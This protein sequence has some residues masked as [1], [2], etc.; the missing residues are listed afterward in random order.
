[1]QGSCDVEVTTGTGLDYPVLLDCLCGQLSLLVLAIWTGSQGWWHLH[2]E[3]RLP[4]SYHSLHALG[5]VIG[6]H[7]SATHCSD[8]Q[9]CATGYM[10]PELLEHAENGTFPMHNCEYCS[11]C[12]E[13][14]GYCCVL[15]YND[16]SKMTML[17]CMSHRL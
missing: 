13:D 10:A 17:K 16:S 2:P 6:T 5:S 4:C 9:R 1:M 15:T 11:Y 12:A 3:P 14:V 7:L 8:P